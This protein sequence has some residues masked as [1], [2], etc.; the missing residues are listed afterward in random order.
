MG[1]LKEGGDVIAFVIFTK[2]LGCCVKNRLLWGQ[3]GPW[4]TT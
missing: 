3:S 4:E 2:H 1:V